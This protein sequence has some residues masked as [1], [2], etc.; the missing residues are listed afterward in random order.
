MG[1]RGQVPMQ[2]GVCQD[3]PRRT[4]SPG[5][6]VRLRIF[7]GS[8]EGPAMQCRPLINVVYASVLGLAGCLSG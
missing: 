5:I 1:I 2:D 7:D 3:G 6:H 8:A 4:E